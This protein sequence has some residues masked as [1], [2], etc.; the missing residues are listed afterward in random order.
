MDKYQL[1]NWEEYLNFEIHEANHDRIVLLFERCVISCALYENFWCKYAH[2]L[3]H[4]HK[5][6]PNSNADLSIHF[7]RNQENLE[8]GSKQET[9][10]EEHRIDD[11]R[12]T[13]SEIISKIEQQEEAEKLE[14]YSTVKHLVNSVALEELKQDHSVFKVL[15]PVI[16]QVVGANTDD[17]SKISDRFFDLAQCY[18]EK[19][20]SVGYIAATEELRTELVSPKLIGVTG[21]FVSMIAPVKSGEQDLDLNNDTSTPGFTTL[22]SVPEFPPAKYVRQ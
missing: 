16:T 15:T 17:L 2:Y 4:Y 18:G 19:V 6:R 7:L 9:E 11:V 13:I 10:E 20:T 14:I 12:G 1:R 21:T 3:E 8:I 22:L 5:K